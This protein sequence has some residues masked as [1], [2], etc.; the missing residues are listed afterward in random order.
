MAVFGRADVTAGAAADLDR[1]E[2]FRSTVEVM[3]EDGV[4]TREEK[5]IIIRLAKALGLQ[6]DQPGMVYAAIQRGEALEA[7][8]PLNHH[9]QREVYGKVVEVALLNAS[10]SRDEF[11]VLQHLQSL[12]HISVDEH[13]RFLART[14]EIARDRLRDPRAIE[15]VMETVRDLSDIVVD[16]IRRPFNGRE[17]A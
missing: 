12:M 6:D 13:N 15:R 5:R 3:L 17:R 10:L 14:E 7:G 4:L 9:Q 11:R 1:I 8:E 16:G 2:V